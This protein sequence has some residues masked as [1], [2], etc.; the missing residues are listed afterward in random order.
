MLKIE[1]S[2]RG[3]NSMPFFVLR[4][5]SFVVHIG[6]IC[7]S[8][9]FVVGEHLRRCTP[10]VA[11]QDRFFN[12]PHWQRAWKWQQNKEKLHRFLHWGKPILPKAIR[13]LRTNSS[14]TTFLLLLHSHVFSNLRKHGNV[15]AKGA[16][17]NQFKVA[18]NSFQHIPRPR[19][20]C[21]I[22]TTLYHLM[23]RSWYQKTSQ[24]LVNTLVLFSWHIR[25]P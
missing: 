18:H 1:T 12:R 19:F 24:L 9:S 4:R 14:K 13:L 15:R 6:I 10:L 7:V 20:W 2:T 22:T 21:V 3:T 16:S 17:K 8:G 5:G 11:F 25:L 23:L